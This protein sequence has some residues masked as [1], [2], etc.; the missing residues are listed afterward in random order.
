MPPKSF[1]EDNRHGRSQTKNFA[2]AARH[3]PLGGCDQDADLRRGQGLRRTPP[4]ASSRPQDRHVQGPAGPEEQE[5][6]LIAP[7]R[8]KV[9]GYEQVLPVRGAT[10]SSTKKL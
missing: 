4:A 1:Q 9:N 3:A 7:R 2:L 10:T 8:Q 5:R 6:I